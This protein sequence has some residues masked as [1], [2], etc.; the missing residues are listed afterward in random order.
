M[1][2]SKDIVLE[3]MQSKVLEQHSDDVGFTT[4]EL[5][6][7]LSMQRSNISKTLNELV[8][9]HR[10]A[11]TNGR[12]VY[13]SLIKEYE[14]SCF[15][16]M[17]GHDS[18]LKQS[19]QL[20]KAAL[21]YPGNS[22]PILITGPD[23]SGKSL[24][25]ELIYTFAKESRMIA[26][27]A[28]FIKV[29]CRYLID[30]E[31]EK[32]KEIFFNNQEG[33][34]EKSR[35]GVLFV[36]HIN[37]LSNEIQSKL[38]NYIEAAQNSCSNAILVYSVDDS[39]TPMYLSLYSSKF[40]IVVDLP[41][42]SKRTFK[43]RFEMIQ[44][45]FQKEAHCVHKSI[46]INSE[47]LRC[48]LLYPCQLNVKQLRRDIQLGCANGYAR[49][50]GS[51]EAQIELCIHDFPNYVRKGFLTYR[52]YRT[53]IEQIVPNNYLYSFSEQET[54]AC[55][56][57][58]SV[59][60]TNSYYNM[61]DRKAEE[62]KKHGVDDEDIMKII[63][64][65]LDYDFQR[66]NEEVGQKKIDKD[67][68]S[69]IV[70]QPII[71]HVDEFLKE[72]SIRF[73]RIYSNSV[74]FALCLHLSAM[75]E[76]KGSSQNLT[77][78]QIVSTIKEHNDEYIFCSKFIDMLEK[79]YN[80]ELSINDVVFL[81]MF[82]TKEQ[83]SEEEGKPVVLV[84]MHGNSTASSIVEVANA[85][86]G[87]GNIYAFDLSLE[88]DMQKV[89]ED[90]SQ[91][92]VE[93]HQG[94]GVLMLYD[95]GSFKTMAEMIQNETGIE[96]KTFCIPATL[97]ALDCSR[98]ASCHHSLDEIYE[99]VVNSYQQMYPELA[100]S[101]QKQE[102]PQVIISLCMTGE[103]AA[104][105]IKKYIEE[106]VH[107]ENTE[108]IPLSISDHEYLLKKVNQI[109]KNQKI[110]CVI[111]AQDPGLY[112]IPFIPISKLFDISPDKLE[113]LLSIHTADAVMSINYDAIY[114]YLQEQLP[115][116]DIP[117][118]KET[119]PKCITQIKNVAHGLSSDQEVGLFMHIACSIHRIQN[120]EQPIKNGNA[121][122]III[123]NKRLYN[124]IRDIL[125][126]LEKEF[127][128]QFNDD[129]IANIIQYI[130]K[131]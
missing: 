8:K 18:S 94:K 14:E 52:K 109:Q 129:E 33:A 70:D 106:H 65:N 120:D 79:E 74:F 127:Y 121:T 50:F 58:N 77:N 125:N 90:L 46:K 111:G 24:L 4:Q 7:A 85:L 41:A 10:V 61:I 68:I 39:I 99:E 107:L 123:K 55:E 56:V 92:I 81:A 32:I 116:F 27:D 88:Q 108:I 21:L 97:I 38:L 44:F 20:T 48:L 36:D 12:P 13:Y 102:K 26:R 114:D 98:K 67:M 59:P 100:Q 131:C 28:P 45:F 91:T 73:D 43:E 128:I 105:Q 95:M 37:R 35:G 64:E 71:Q 54:N 126:L 113:L 104:I 34:M 19:I 86:V 115:D 29:N 122:Q 119:L 11:K 101:Y 60:D 22:L 49:N 75:I 6:E 16:E 103:G 31:D 112:G 72:A 23:G 76:R 9:E 57:E 42:L 130:K 118:L 63:H 51:E 30:E 78:E 89:Y 25:A 93:I 96:I 40:S 3:Y 87:D 117:L 80:L 15:S 1:K 84:A 110:V 124:N 82:I 47:V 83:I 66:I 17:I 2:L 53:Q 5:S 69:K 62:L